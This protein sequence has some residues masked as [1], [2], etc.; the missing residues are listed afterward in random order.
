MA[1]L[2]FRQIKSLAVRQGFPRDKAETLAAIALAE[3]GGNPRAVYKTDREYSVG[4]YQINLKAHPYI[5]AA[6]AYNPVTATQW[7][8]QISGGGRDFTPWTAYTSG[9][10]KRFLG[11]SVVQPPPEPTVESVGDLTGLPDLPIPPGRKLIDSSDSG[12]IKS[13]ILI[14]AIMLLIYAFALIRG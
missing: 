6:E 5:T 9:A 1:T 14:T 8:Y 10:Y 7:A 3:S 13:V 12:L 11:R 4:L 2:S